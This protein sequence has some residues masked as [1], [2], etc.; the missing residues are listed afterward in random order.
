MTD[1]DNEWVQWIRE[2]PTMRQ[3]VEVL[4]KYR[5]KVLEEVEKV[6]MDI[7][8]VLDDD[9]FR[10]W[11]TKGGSFAKQIVAAIAALKGET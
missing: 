3:A 10:K 2:Q 1:F 9:P 4:R 11:S 7:E 8:F 6:V 5:R